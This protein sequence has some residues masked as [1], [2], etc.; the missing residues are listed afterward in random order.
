MVTNFQIRKLNSQVHSL[1]SQIK[2][3]EKN[4]KVKKW[5]ENSYT[6]Q[7]QRNTFTKK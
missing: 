4:M 5:R 2:R 6:A 1:L 7:K 3:I